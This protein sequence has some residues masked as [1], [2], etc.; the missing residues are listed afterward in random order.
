MAN[1]LGDL[2]SLAEEENLVGVFDYS[3][4]RSLL[5]RVSSKKAPMDTEEFWRD[6][7]AS[8]DKLESS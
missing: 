1:G 4:F 8:H 2:A 3:P 7:R 5:A 6:E